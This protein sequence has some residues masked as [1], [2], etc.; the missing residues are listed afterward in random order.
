MKEGKTRLMTAKMHNVFKV[1][2]RLTKKLMETETAE[3]Y[4]DADE[5]DD[6]DQE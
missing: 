5:Y 6:N 1:D 3:V 2:T 4:V